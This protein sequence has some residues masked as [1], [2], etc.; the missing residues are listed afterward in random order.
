MPIPQA[1]RASSLYTK[2]P[3]AQRDL[4]LSVL[5]ISDQQY[6]GGPIPQ[7]WR[8]SPP[9][10]CV[11]VGDPCAQTR[12]LPS[13]VGTPPSRAKQGSSGSA[14]SQRSLWLGAIFRLA[15]YLSAIDNISW[16]QSLRLGATPRHSQVR[17][18]DPLCAETQSRR[19]AKKEADFYQP[20]FPINCQ[21]LSKMNISPSKSF[22]GITGKPEYISIAPS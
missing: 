21:I 20:L 22:I 17:V 13:A 7:A 14:V 10:L 9:L 18:V 12:Q 1:L 3:L 6:F 5:S 16:D 2:E 8:Y 19:R 4:S 11:R 15:C